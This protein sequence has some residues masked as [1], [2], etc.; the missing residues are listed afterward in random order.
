LRPPVLIA[1]A[2]WVL[3]GV[4]YGALKTNGFRRKLAFAEVPLE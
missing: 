2:I 4:I 3:A 1:G